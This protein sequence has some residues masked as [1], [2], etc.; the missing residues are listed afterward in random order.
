M[1]KK[2]LRTMGWREGQGVGSRVRRQRKRAAQA[3]FASGDEPPEEE[4]PEQARA[5][6][7][8]KAKALV[9]TEGLTFAPTNT[10]I[11]AQAVVARTSLHGV[12]H[13]PFQGAPEFCSAR[14]V[15]IGSEAAQSVYKTGDL[16]HHPKNG[17]GANAGGAQGRHFVSTV[18][19]RGSHGFFVDDGEDDVYEGSF[20]KEAYDNALDAGGDQILHSSFTGTAKA[21]AL[22]KLDGEDAPAV[23]SRRYAR[24]PSDGRLPLAGFV[25]AQ[26]L[27]GTPHH[28]EPPIPPANFN[29]IHR[30]EEEQANPPLRICTSGGKSGMNA[31]GRAR[32]LGEPSDGQAGSV[33]VGSLLPS[34]RS[35]P[36]PAQ[37]SVFSLLSS[38]ARKSLQHAAHCSQEQPIKSHFK[39]ASGQD[40]KAIGASGGPF[41]APCGAQRQVRVGG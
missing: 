25:V 24:C 31:L 35:S 19:G 8:E 17:A 7:G 14:G 32:L 6:L 1:G 9:E 30:F 3:T 27:D 20:G 11:K 28:W 40:L 2:L 36:L 33:F 38:A 21:W 12:G 34:E 22:G 15:R 26:Q 39:T 5:G 10:N 18:V 37:A 23:A 13:D 29:P 4:L 16:I 41:V